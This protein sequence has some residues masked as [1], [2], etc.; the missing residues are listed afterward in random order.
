[1][2]DKEDKH[3][4]H[5][6]Y[7]LVKGSWESATSEEEFNK[8]IERGKAALL[9]PN[10]SV[11]SSATTGSSAVI[12]NAG[13]TANI[14]SMASNFPHSTT[15]PSSTSNVTS[16]Q[17][18]QVQASMRMTQASSE[19]FSIDNYWKKI[20]FLSKCE[21]FVDIFEAKIE[22]ELNSLSLLSMEIK[23]DNKQKDIEHKKQKYRNMKESLI[24]IKN[25]MKLA[26]DERANETITPPLF[27]LVLHMEKLII[28]TQQRQKNKKENASVEVSTKVDQAAAHP[29]SSTA[30]RI[31][32]KPPIRAFLETISAMEREYLPQLHVNLKQLAAKID[33]SPDSPLFDETDDLF[34]KQRSIEEYDRENANNNSTYLGKRKRNIASSNGDPAPSIDSNQAEQYLEKYLIKHISHLNLTLVDTVA[35]SIRKRKN[36]HYSIHCIIQSPA[37][38]TIPIFVVNVI[39]RNNRNDED[40]VVEVQS[41]QF[42]SNVLDELNSIFLIARNRFEKGIREKYCKDL[43]SVKKVSHILSKWIECIDSVLLDDSKLS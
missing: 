39:M 22:Q 16:A 14:S 42:L 2:K 35:F 38:Q 34:T 15:A 6:A 25:Q 19:E 37:L 3:I 5:C 30:E 12:I 20:D 27:Q 13:I 10:V 24:I 32:T 9:N 8:N 17:A 43:Q 7:R 36:D 26:K 31:P 29:V 28:N 18:Q 1:L 40:N 11:S 21:N 23:D 4:Q 41:M 33:V